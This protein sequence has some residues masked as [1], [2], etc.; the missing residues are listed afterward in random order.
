MMNATS[1]RIATSAAM[2]SPRRR[3]LDDDMVAREFLGI[4]LKRAVSETVLARTAF[5]IGGLAPCPT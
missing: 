2:M 5:E 3:R 1:A 4:R